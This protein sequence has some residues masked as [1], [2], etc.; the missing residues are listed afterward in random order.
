LLVLGSGGYKNVAAWQEDDILSLHATEMMR[1]SA[2]IMERIKEKDIT[3]C[4]DGSMKGDLYFE[5]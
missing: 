2:L 4:P 1:I 3:I 5:D